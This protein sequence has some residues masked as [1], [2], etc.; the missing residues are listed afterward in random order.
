MHSRD[1]SFTYFPRDELGDL[2]YKFFK[3]VIAFHPIRHILAAQDWD[4]RRAG[5]KFAV[6]L[7]T[8]LYVDIIDATVRRG[9][10]RLRVSSDVP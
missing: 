5:A 4:V 3:Q 10:A 1:T 7:F 8:F 6:A 2:R 9:V